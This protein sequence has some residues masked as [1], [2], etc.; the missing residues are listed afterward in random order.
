[1]LVAIVTARTSPSL[2]GSFMTFAIVSSTA[3]TKKQ[4]FLKDTHG[5]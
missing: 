4:L 5:D 1:M 3:T 2:G